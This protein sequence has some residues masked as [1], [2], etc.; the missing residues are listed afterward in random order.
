VV[1][2]TRHGVKI[3]ALVSPNVA[4]GILQ[5]QGKDGPVFPGDLAGAIKMIESFLA[6]DGPG[7]DVRDVHSRRCELVGA[8]LTFVDILLSG[9]VLNFGELVVTE[10]DES[11]RL[12]VIAG[13]LLRKLYRRPDVQSIGGSALP[14]IAGS[15]WAAQMGE[16]AF[17]H[18][19]NI[20][21]PVT[22][23]EVWTWFMSICELC[24]LINAIRGDGTAEGLLYETEETFRGAFGNTAMHEEQ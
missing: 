11:E 13:M 21:T 22:D 24:A 14:I 9:P 19:R 1:H 2:I 23:G 6:G 7:P 8:F 5:I 10:D 18:R 12:E 4:D 16:S 3:A 15:M 17:Q 20:P